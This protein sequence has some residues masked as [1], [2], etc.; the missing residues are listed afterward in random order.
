MYYW[1]A[2]TFTFRRLNWYANRL[3][4]LEYSLGECRMVNTF[5]G[6]FLFRSLFGN[7]PQKF[8]K[9][10]DLADFL[11]KRTV[12]KWFA[13]HAH[14]NPTWAIKKWCWFA[15]TYL[16]ITSHRLAFSAP[17][18]FLIPAAMRLFLVI[19][20]AVKDQENTHGF[21]RDGEKRR[22]QNS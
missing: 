9:R 21:L 22:G 13:K 15:D 19:S 5:K 10:M 3:K 4:Q 8:D 14:K 6:V 18:N 2:W 12:Y 7:V 16:N 20:V 17:C 11:P 1:W